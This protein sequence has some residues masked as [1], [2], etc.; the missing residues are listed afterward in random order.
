MY[1]FCRITYPGILHFN[2]SSKNCSSKVYTCFGK[3]A[4]LVTQSTTKLTLQ[5]FLFFLRFYTIFQSCSYNTTHGEESTFTPP[6]P[7]VLNLHKNCPCLQHLG[8][9]VQKALTEV[10]SAAGMARRWWCGPGTSKQ[11][12]QARFPSPRV[13]WPQIGGGGHSDERAQWRSATAAAAARAPA[14]MGTELSNAWHG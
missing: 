9:H 6:P 2:F 14:K 7:E 3:V 8:P 1:G 10:S 11:A 5:F 12:T 4:V 13:D